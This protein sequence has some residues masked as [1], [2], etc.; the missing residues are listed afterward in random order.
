MTIGQFIASLEAFYTDKYPEIV[1]RD[2]EAR[3]GKNPW[4][5]IA[6]KELFDLVTL[7]HSRQFRIAPDK[8]IL[9]P[10]EEMAL[11]QRDLVLL[12]R[13][14]IPGQKLLTGTTREQE[15]E[16]MAKLL[17]TLGIKYKGLRTV[18]NG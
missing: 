9:Q 1:R 17:A 8:A 15:R 11:D 10:L 5:D 16:E 14:P 3:Y 7:K 18:R 13:K 6:R 12:S 2:I 4:G